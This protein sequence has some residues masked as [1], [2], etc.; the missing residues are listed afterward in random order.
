MSELEWFFLVVSLG[1]AIT[2]VFYHFRYSGSKSGN[3]KSLG[4]KS[5]RVAILKHKGRVN[6]FTVNIEQAGLPECSF[7]SRKKIHHF[8]ERFSNAETRVISDQNFSERI[9]TLCDNTAVRMELQ[10]N[11]SLRHSLVELF[12]RKFPASYKIQAIHCYRNSLS[13]RYTA[14]G[15]PKGEFINQQAEEIAP[16]LF[17]ITENL[18]RVSSQGAGAL[19]DPNLTTVGLVQ[20]LGAALGIVGFAQFIKIIGLENYQ[21]LHV[22]PFVVFAGA[23]GLGTIIMFVFV[24]FI[25]LRGSSRFY[26]AIIEFVCF[27]SIGILLSSYVFLFSINTELDNSPTYK[28]TT[29]VSR[30]YTETT[31]RKNRRTITYH[32][33]LKDRRNIAE[34]SIT[35]NLTPELYKSLSPGT[36]VDLSIRQGYFGYPY[37]IKYHFQEESW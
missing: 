25:L 8:F 2:Y 9:H 10:L 17:N 20:A 18:A 5:Y 29:V 12:T 13:A 37:I 32:A 6:G 34:E 28:K 3:I 23:V 27:G 19:K 16:L 14:K 4:D 36:E 24:I 31:K 35:I 22:Y 15:N 26:R 7:V 1:T 30:T 21:P 11:S 33:E